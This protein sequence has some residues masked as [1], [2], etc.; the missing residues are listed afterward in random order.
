[1]KSTVWLAI[2][3][4]AWATILLSHDPH[5]LIAAGCLAILALAATSHRLWTTPTQSR[6]ITLAILALTWFAT[7]AILYRRITH[8]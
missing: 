6:P 8:P 7:I 4:V 2:T 3:L 5:M 1:M